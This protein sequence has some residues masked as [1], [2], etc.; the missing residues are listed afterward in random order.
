MSS[1][2]SSSR[3]RHDSS[4]R[5]PFSFRQEKW[6]FLHVTGYYPFAN[7]M[8]DW[9]KVAEKYKAQF[10]VERTAGSRESKWK[11]MMER[12]VN[13]KFYE[14]GERPSLI[15]A[16]PPAN[17]PTANHHV[18]APAVSTSSSAASTSSQIPQDS[19]SS[20]T[21]S[22]NQPMNYTGLPYTAEETD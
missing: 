2:S 8:V 18:P 3:R 19:R 10:P 6:L 12:G 17:P 5:V 4:S 13:I 11:E 14:H 9:D 15:H 20:S 16:Q 7:T 22:D 1:V 21:S